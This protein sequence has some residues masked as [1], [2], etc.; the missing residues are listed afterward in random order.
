MTTVVS[1]SLYPTQGFEHRF[2]HGNRYHCVSAKVTL[3]WDEHGKLSA[4]RRQRDWVRNDAWYGEPDRSTLLVPSELNP[5]KP[6]TDVLVSGTV[7]PPEGRPAREWVGALCIAEQIKRLRFFGTRQWQHSALRGWHLSEAVPVAG[8]ALLLE[9]AYGGTIGAPREHYEEGDYFAPNPFG[10]GYVGRSRPDTSQPVRAAQ[11]EAWDGPITQFGADVAVGALGPV[12]GFF[13]SRARY[14]GTLD[15]QWQAHVKPNIPLDMDMRYWNTALP[16]QQAK[17]YLRPG[18]AIT[19]VGLLPG[20][21]LRLK[22]PPIDPALLCEY[23]DDQRRALAMNL[24]TVA[25]DLDQRCMSLRYHQILPFD[26]RIARI[27]IHCAPYAA[28]AEH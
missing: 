24:D 18:D 27:N 3:D 2:Y 26:E 10:C 15:A 28:L 21:P 22:I 1:Q 20:E 11:I 17:E 6:T 19:L 9:N 7:Q 23:G 25:I 13:P 16:D 8:V 5:Y 14:M 12:P 4:P